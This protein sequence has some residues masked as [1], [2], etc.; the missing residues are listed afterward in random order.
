MDCPSEESMIRMKLDSVGR[1]SKL[2]FDI[3]NRKLTVFHNGNLEEI[4]EAIADLKFNEELISS[5]PTDEVIA[6]EASNQSRLL[7]SV[8][9]INFMFFVIEMTTGLISKSMGLVADT[10]CGYRNCRNS[11]KVYKSNRS[12]GF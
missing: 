8:L 10:S 12:S 11:E 6:E 3:P 5:E 4:Q 7:W 9:I 1:I 2:D